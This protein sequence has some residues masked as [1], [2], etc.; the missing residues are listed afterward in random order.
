VGRAVARLLDAAGVE[1]TGAGRTERGRDVP[2]V[3]SYVAVERI[4][5]VLPGIDALVLACPLTDQ[6]RHLITDHELRLM[7]PGAVVVNISRGP[8]IDED[9]LISALSRQHLG[10]ACLD[11]FAT[12]PLAADSPLWAMENVIISPHS[13]STVAAE[14]GLITDLFTDNLQRFLAG[15]PLRNVYDRD[16][17]Y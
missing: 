17:G 9:A 12:E 7:P 1:V 3:T 8:V 4:G 6:T 11:V 13:A 5:E 16:A 14:N 15:K 2:G 10:G